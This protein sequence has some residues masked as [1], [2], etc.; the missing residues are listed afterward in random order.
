MRHRKAALAG[1]GLL[2]LAFVTAGFYYP[3]FLGPEV[4]SALEPFIDSAERQSQCTVVVK[5]CHGERYA[6]N[7]KYEGIYDA[8]NNLRGECKAY[9]GPLDGLDYDAYYR[10]GECRLNASTT[11][12]CGDLGPGGCKHQRQVIDEHYQ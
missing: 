6:I 9:G 2:F 10:G 4:A 8:I 1:A 3:G 7:E 5:G 12:G 11:F